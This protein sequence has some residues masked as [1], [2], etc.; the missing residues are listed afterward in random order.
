M[1]QLIYERRKVF[2]PLLRFTHLWLGVLI[3]LQIFTALIVDYIDKGVPRDTLW[4]IH[5][6]IGYGIGV[7][8]VARIILGIMGSSTAKFSDLWHP[9]LWL[10]VIKTKQWV[11]PHRWGHSAL[12]S[13]VYLVFY[14]LLSVMVLTGLSLAAIKLNMGP[15]DSLLGGN[16]ALKDLFHEPH[17]L[18]YNFFWGFILVHFGAL[19]WHEVKDKSPLAQAMVSGYLYRL[20]SKNDK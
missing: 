7:G 17:E 11:D 16:K 4:Y 6:W 18:L 8:L 19:I 13:F 2:D 5:V 12:A 14:V 15:F 3:V 10:N 1:E 20:I 9:A